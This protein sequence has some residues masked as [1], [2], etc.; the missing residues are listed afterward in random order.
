MP[1][2][3]KITSFCTE[4]GVT[5]WFVGGNQHQR[6]LNLINSV[7]RLATEVNA[8]N[9]F[10]DSRNST[11]W[12]K[13]WLVKFIHRFEN[14]KVSITDINH[15]GNVNHPV[16]HTEAIQAVIIYARYKPC[17]GHWYNVQDILRILPLFLLSIQ[18]QNQ[19]QGKSRPLMITYC[20]S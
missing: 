13:W 11:T 16:C 6:H 15:S 18:S 12:E 1:C 14:Y 5:A 19:I 4:L 2:E 8:D 17:Y 3:G 9:Y 7:G 10:F 20:H